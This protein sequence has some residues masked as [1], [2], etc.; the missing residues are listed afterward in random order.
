M[1]LNSNW[2]M[3]PVIDFEMKKYQL[4]AYLQEKKLDL[5]FNKLYYSH[6]DLQE[7]V[8][9]LHSLLE[10]K[11]EMEESFQKELEKMDWQKLELKYKKENHSNYS[12]D[13]ILEIVF[14]AYPKIK[15]YSEQFH[16][17]IE[18]LKKEIH[19]DVVGILPNY[20]KEGFLIIEQPQELYLFAYDSNVLLKLNGEKKIK[21]QHIFTYSNSIL[22]TPSQIKKEIII[23][24]KE[25]FPNPA[26]FMV[27]CSTELP[28]FESV[29]P[30][31]LQQLEK[32]IA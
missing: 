21:Y 26:V 18:N 28:I 14:Y 5:E 11:N 31:S 10:N 19:L 7:R 1:K 13:Q 20:L 12:L 3:E 30:L 2:F 32:F 24:Y 17:A 15:K 27:Y 25:S 6:L 16:F 9:A 29:L 8:N 4:L 22:N 23:E